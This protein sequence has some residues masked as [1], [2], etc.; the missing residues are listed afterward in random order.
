MFWIFMSCMKAAP[1]T[2]AEFAAALGWISCLFTVD[3]TLCC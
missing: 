3:V 2:T 1:R